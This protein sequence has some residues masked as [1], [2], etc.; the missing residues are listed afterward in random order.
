MEFAGSDRFFLATVGLLIVSAVWIA[1]S[2]R[3]PMAFDEDFHLGV[4]RLYTHH[5]NPFWDGQ[6]AGGGVYGAVSRDPSY[7]YH[8]LMSFPY[9]LISSLTADQH[10]QVMF[11]RFINIGFLASGL[12]VYR[13]LLLRSKASKAVV[14]LTLLILVL[15]PITPL[16]A[17][18]I[19]YDNL[20]IP[21]VGLALL[22]TLKLHATNTN[23][24]LNA[25]LFL[26]LTGISLFIC[27]LK[28]AF[29]PIFVALIVYNAI[30]L[31][32]QYP[33]PK[34]YWSARRNGLKTIQKPL[35]VL[36]VFINLVFG[37][38]FIER[39]G[40][41]LLH[42]HKPVADCGE[43]LDYQHCQFYGPWIRD[44]NF[45]ANKQA[46]QISPA[47]YTQ[48]WFYGMWFRTFFAV[49][50]PATGFQTRGPLVL[51][52]LSGITFAVVGL[53]AL[54]LSA[55]KL[56]SKY[57]R[58][59]LWLMSVVASFY[60]LSLWI[61][62][63]KLYVRT[64]QPVAINGRY[65]LPV[66]P[67]FIILALLAFKEISSSKPRLQLALSALLIFGLA[68]GGGALTY[69]LRSNDDWYWRNNLFVTDIS[70]AVQNK[71]GPFIPGYNNPTEF[72]H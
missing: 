25:K 71:I 21:L 16:L 40:V 45:E 36:L 50:G 69:V 15:I 26:S 59:A 49:D 1:L 46:T 41:N 32:K 57:N 72:L 18:Q 54:L 7:M 52:G 61:E 5:P 66:L 8:Y 62:E 17:A 56:W 68:W 13:R 60:V 70:H 11:L 20:F 43:V 9:R 35:L 4:I 2:G 3:F 30:Y 24:K 64:G 51:P 12:F 31:R 65:L 67:L 23:T 10:K 53:A 29:L 33:T 19:N 48:H 27:V 39:Y 63:Y 22:L 34:L 37:S 42:Y 38:L 47:S 44:Y 14:N 28:Y 55:K 6:A 58:P